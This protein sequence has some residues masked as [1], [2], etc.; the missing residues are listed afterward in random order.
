LDFSSIIII[1]LGSTFGLILRIFILNNFKK[2]IGF[3]IQYSI[4]S[5]GTKKLRIKAVLAI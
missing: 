2:N 1:L 4:D 5:F 3:D